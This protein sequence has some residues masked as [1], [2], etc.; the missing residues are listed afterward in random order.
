[1]RTIETTTP[2]G[3]KAL[4]ALNRRSV[5]AHDVTE[6][7][8]GVLSDIA[9]RGDAAVIEYTQR[10]DRAKLTPKQLSVPASEL[11]AAWKALPPATKRVLQASYKNVA[12]FARRGLRKEWSMK[13]HQGATVGETYRGYE[14]VGIYIPGGTAPLVSSVL[15]TVTYARAAGCRE[16][17]VCTPCGTDGQ[18]NAT[19]L[20][21]LHLA[22]ATEVYRIGG[23]QAI[24]AMTYGT[25]TIR[26]VHKI[27]GP[28]NKF[29]TEAKRQVFG[30]VS[31]DLLA[32]PS[33]IM[34]LAEACDQ[35]EWLAA[36]L[37]AQA[38]HGPGSEAIFVSPSATLITAVKKHLQAQAQSL[39][40]QAALKEADIV[41][42]RTRTLA[43]AIAVTN[44]YAPEH[45]EVIVR[46][47]KKVL[48]QLTTAGAIF[49]GAHSP[50]AA[51]DFLAGPSHT[52]PTGGAAKSFAGLTVEAFQHRSSVIK[53]DARSIA[54]SAPLIEAFA[55]L[56]GLDAH[57]R[58]AS[59][60]LKS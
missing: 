25:K 6:L 18:I 59:L 47:E 37:L 45:L 36:D 11:E 13:N 23:I 52:L 9:Q 27:F 40:R 2:A 28:G 12:T 39:S 42:I 60:R 53:F 56:E 14:R 21:A 51:G 8:A 24:G 5:P 43:E 48:A 54:K 22:G 19:L 34:I 20:G 10:F 50:V 32:G 29:V 17:V 31:I 33:D 41:F 15:M 55:Q 7:V 44:S 16:I 35:P 30:Q 58:S 57:A 49:L 46:E 1:M 4:Q 38:E 26:L 3:K